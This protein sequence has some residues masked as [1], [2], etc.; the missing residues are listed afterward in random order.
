MSVSE[1]LTVSRDVRYWLT[2]PQYIGGVSLPLWLVKE[3]EES[4]VL[5][6]RSDLAREIMLLAVKSHSGK[7]DFGVPKIVIPKLLVLK[8]PARSQTH[9]FP[10]KLKPSLHLA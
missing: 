2:W 4:G 3:F 10:A 1:D 6:W 7:L 8:T 5:E 9:K